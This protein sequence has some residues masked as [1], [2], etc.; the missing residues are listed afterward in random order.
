MAPLTSSRICFSSFLI[1]YTLP[2]PI[3]Y[4]NAPYLLL[5]CQA[6]LGVRFQAG[7]GGH[8]SAHDQSINTPHTKTVSSH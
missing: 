6:D 3:T 1:G 8:Q 5:A 2:S 4:H 7:T